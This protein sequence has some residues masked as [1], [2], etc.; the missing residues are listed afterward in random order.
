MYMI[1]LG[2][3]IYVAAG[4]YV[5]GMMTTCWT[6]SYTNIRKHCTFMLIFN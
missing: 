1:H 5:Y 2:I 6:S 3:V 4:I